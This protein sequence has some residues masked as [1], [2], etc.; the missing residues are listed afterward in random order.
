MQGL[1]VVPIISMEHFGKVLESLIA[2]SRYD[3][4]GFARHADISKSTL[5]LN[6][7]SPIP[8]GRKGTYAKIAEALG[9][10]AEQLDS[11]WKD[12]AAASAADSTFDQEKA[13]ST[14][15]SGFV[16][17]VQSLSKLT[18]VER[19]ALRAAM[20]AALDAFDRA[21]QNPRASGPARTS[22]KAG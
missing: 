16:D 2:A 18:A 7:E 20:I 22:R 8:I 21:E 13:V 15:V 3:K 1:S 9:L 4:I 5:Y 11:K 6:L 17:S 19:S 14:P 12:P 10:S